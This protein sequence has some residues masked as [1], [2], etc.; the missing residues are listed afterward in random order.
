MVVSGFQHLGVEDRSGPHVTLTAGVDLG[1]RCWSTTVATAAKVRAIRAGSAGAVLAEDADGW[2]LAVGPISVLDIRRPWGA[3]SDPVTVGLA[4]LAVARLGL[5]HVDQLAGYVRDGAAVPTRWRPT[6]RV[7]VVLDPEHRL[8]GGPGFLDGTGRFSRPG[9]LAAATRRRRLRP[10]IAV[11]ADLPPAARRLV[12]RSGPCAV[13]L[14]SSI[15]PV[16]VPGRWDPRGSVGVDPLVLRHVH[17]TLPGRC[18]VTIDDSD[19]PRPS[20]KL[21]VMLRGE[22]GLLGS[23]DPDDVEVAVRIDR[24]IGWHGFDTGTRRAS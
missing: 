11:L 4:G 8:R 2:T 10:A 1:G 16:V 12:G 13:G 24:A 21:G 19:C 23:S 7:L 5:A 14:S 18:A 17:A 9:R 6:E 20:G 22:A 15:G 3:L